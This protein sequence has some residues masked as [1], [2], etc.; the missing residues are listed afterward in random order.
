VVGV[1]VNGETV[2]ADVVVVAMGPWSGLAADFFPGSGLPKIRG[3]RAHSIVL[4]V[5]VC[6][7]I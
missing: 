1:V 4:D 3:S 2:E 7:Y 6:S 5:Q